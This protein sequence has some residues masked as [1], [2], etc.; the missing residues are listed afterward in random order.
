MGR[1]TLFYTLFNAAPARSIASSTNAAPIVVTSSA[2]HGLTTGDSVT[3]E[4]HLVNTAANGT[5]VVTV[6]TS[7]TFEL[8]G[9]TGNGI[10]GATGTIAFVTPSII[11]VTDF[12][13][14]VLSFDTDGGG[15]AAMTVKTVGSIAEDQPTFTSAQ[16]PSNQYDFVDMID[17]EDGAAVPGDTG[18]VVA[19]AD[20]NRMFEVN[21][22]G[23]R[24]LSVLMTVGGAGEITV[25][26]RTFTNR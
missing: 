16:S 19:T 25:R 6:L 11:D 26:L 8:N 9:T 14:V 13:N 22:N 15:D 7:T 5:N 12:R 3:I 20:D 21:T 4:S 18:F 1:I 2:A 17:L 10:G 24:W 23:I